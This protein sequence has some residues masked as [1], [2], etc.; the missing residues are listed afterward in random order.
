MATNI[1]KKQLSDQILAAGNTYRPQPGEVLT[2]KSVGLEKRSSNQGKE[3]SVCVFQAKDG[4]SV[5]IYAGPILAN[6]LAYFQIAEDD[7]VILLCTGYLGAFAQWQLVG[8]A[9]A[10]G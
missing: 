9:P 7:E 6:Q 1:T 3:Y 8:K 4:R 5:D 2:A 10:T